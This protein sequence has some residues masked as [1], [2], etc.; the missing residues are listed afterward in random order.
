MRGPVW[1][2]EFDPV[3]NDY[4]RHGRGRDRGAP[5][6]LENLRHALRIR[7]RNVSQDIVELLTPRQRA[8]VKIKLD[9]LSLINGVMR[10]VEYRQ[11]LV[12][13]KRI[14]SVKNEVSSTGGDLNAKQ[15]F[16]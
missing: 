7:R 1:R 15:F 8:S 14:F 16:R 6:R 9:N 3:G 2:F 10:N 12:L 4:K 5:Q 13:G 11:G